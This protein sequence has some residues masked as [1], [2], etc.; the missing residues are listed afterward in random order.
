MFIQR[1]SCFNVGSWRS[2]G[3]GVHSTDQEP[4]SPR[5][6]RKIGQHCLG[7]AELTQFTTVKEDGGGDRSQ[8]P[9]SKRSVGPGFRVGP[10]FVR[11]VWQSRAGL[12][13]DVRKGGLTDGP[14]MKWQT[15]KQVAC[16]EKR[17]LLTGRRAPGF[18]HSGRSFHLHVCQ[19]DRTIIHG[20][21]IPRF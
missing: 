9:R 18:C 21:G 17:H 15:S 6:G 14:I 2:P 12:V 1:M 16:L 20:A 13:T 10:C 7:T 19:I 3:R 8:H 4:R 5:L 11:R